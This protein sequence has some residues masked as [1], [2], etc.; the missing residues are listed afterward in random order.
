MCVLPV[1]VR[2]CETG[3]CFYG[4]LDKAALYGRYVSLRS[5]CLGRWGRGVAFG[6]VNGGVVFCKEEEFHLPGQ[7][8]SGAGVCQVE[9]VFVDQHGLVPDPLCPCFFADVVVDAFAEFAGVRGTLESFGFFVQFD[10]LNHACH[11]VGVL[12]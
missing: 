1:I 9:A 2:V 8:L 5:L 4:R 12:L 10:T 7:V 6:L 3:V 11:V